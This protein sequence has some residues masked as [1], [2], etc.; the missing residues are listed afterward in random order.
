MK[1]PD[2]KTIYKAYRS[3]GFNHSDAFAN[4]V[5]DIKLAMGI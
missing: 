3:Y 1:K 5:E 4:A 2:F